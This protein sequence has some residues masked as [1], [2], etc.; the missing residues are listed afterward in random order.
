MC[1]LPFVTGSDLNHWGIFRV[2]KI[3]VRDKNSKKLQARL[4]KVCREHIA[5]RMFA[6]RWQCFPPNSFFLFMLA[7][8]DI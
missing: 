3:D 7:K 1:V 2:G 8:T 6:L 4:T 5:I